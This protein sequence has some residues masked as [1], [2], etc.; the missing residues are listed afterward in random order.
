MRKAS[1]V[2]LLLSFSLCMC[3]PLFAQKITGTITGVVTDPQG[4]AVS[5]AEVTAKNEGTGATRAATTNASG[6]YVVPDLSPGNYEVHG[7][8]HVYRRHG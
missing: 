8:W 4:A 1:W 2:V 7:K 5:G 3:A 6:V